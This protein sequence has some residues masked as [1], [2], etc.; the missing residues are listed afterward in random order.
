ME[1]PLRDIVE[2][3]THS[4]QMEKGILKFSTEGTNCVKTFTAHSKTLILYHYMQYIVSY[5]HYGVQGQ[6]CKQ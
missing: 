5:V 1:G 3:G 2:W 6:G 4:N